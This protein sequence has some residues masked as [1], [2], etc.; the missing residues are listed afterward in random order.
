MNG[1]NE[2]YEWKRGERGRGGGS[3]PI[4]G[5]GKIFT[6]NSIHPNIGL[7][8]ERFVAFILYP[9]IVH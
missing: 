4:F 9:N 6:E 3:P 1:D 5:G 8:Q 2:L 7:K